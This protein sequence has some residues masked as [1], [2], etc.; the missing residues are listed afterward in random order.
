M[1]T[2]DQEII[3]FK[4]SF[5]K[6]NSTAAGTGPE[7]LKQHTC[8]CPA[9]IYA[10]LVEEPFSLTMQHISLL[11]DYQIYVLY[12]GERDKNGRKESLDNIP[13]R[14]LWVPQIE[15]QNFINMGMQFG[16]KRAD[17]E[18]EWDARHKDII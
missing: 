2:F 16:R 8:Y 7:R 13:S 14:K 5:A 6:K 10:A 9:N 11:T 17:L 3:G 12:F 1:F 18:K 15:K 4:F